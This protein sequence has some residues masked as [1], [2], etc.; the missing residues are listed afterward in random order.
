MEP[1]KKKDPVVTLIH[2]DEITI[3]AGTQA[4]AEICEDTVADYAAAM[5][6]GD[7]FPPVV[8]FHDGKKYYLGDGFHRVLAS[9][10]AEFTEV[11]AEVRKG[12]RQDALWFAVSA[13]RTNGKRMTRQDVRHAIGIVLR[14]FPDRSD[15][16][17]GEQIGCDGKTVASVR[18]DM[19]SGA[20]IPQVEK[21][22][23][24]DGKQYPATKPAT[25]DADTCSKCQHPRSEHFNGEECQ[26]LLTPGRKESQCAC[27]Q[28]V[29][30]GAAAA[31]KSEEPEDL[32]DDPK[33]DPKA[34]RNYED[35]ATAI[36]EACGRME[37][38]VPTL[39]KPMLTRAMMAAAR[40]AKRLD[41]LATR[42]GE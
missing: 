12:T 27:C 40:L 42:I 10:R 38:L 36:A 25:S 18:S 17:I 35:D 34:W 13:N 9:Q 39:P 20:E 21:R 4:R 31:A 41:K 6:A 28:F 23:G 8:L 1:M 30:R 29:A 19:E 11:N 22:T 16:E 26:V 2:P 33:P 37:A 14:E 3:D 32:E 5:L 15:R 7:Q 24:A